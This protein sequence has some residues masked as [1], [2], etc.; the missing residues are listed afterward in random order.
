MF[1]PFLRGPNLGNYIRVTGDVCVCSRYAVGARF[2]ILSV[3]SVCIPRAA[4][5]PFDAR[6][7]IRKNGE[8]PGSRRI[9]GSIEESAGIHLA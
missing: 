7:N 1:S 5:A 4:Y 8:R 2:L 9:D 6:P 3:P